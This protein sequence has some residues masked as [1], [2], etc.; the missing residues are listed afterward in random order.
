M[1]QVHNIGAIPYKNHRQQKYAYMQKSQNQRDMYMYMNVSD[2]CC[3][4]YRAIIPRRQY[5]EFY[6]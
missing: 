5:A 6:H 1:P 3:L 2:A 4:L